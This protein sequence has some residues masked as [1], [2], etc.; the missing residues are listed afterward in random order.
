M[1]LGDLASAIFT[2]VRAV[3][4]LDHP[5][6][7]RLPYLKP[8]DVRAKSAPN[9]W[10]DDLRVTAGPGDVIVPRDGERGAALAPNDPVVPSAGVLVARIGD[11]ERA[12]VVAHHLDSVAGQSVR[13]LLV[14]GTSF[15]PHLN[16]SAL[17]RFP[18]PAEALQPAIHESILNDRPGAEL[19]PPPLAERLQ[20]ILWS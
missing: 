19:P 17:A 6:P 12:T 5:G 11:P 7:G 1:P 18:L 9:T 14:A 16:R 15:V 20:R 13:R 3:T 4:E 2:G 8:R 10:T